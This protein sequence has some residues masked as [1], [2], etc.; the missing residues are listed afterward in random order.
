MKGRDR[1]R[2]L[3]GQWFETCI[4]LHLFA[5]TRANHLSK[6]V[7]PNSCH[8]LIENDITSLATDPKPFAVQ[9]RRAVDLDYFVKLCAR[10][11]E[12]KLE[13]TGGIYVL[14]NEQRAG[15][16]GTLKFKCMGCDKFKHVS[17]EN[18]EYGNSIDTAFVL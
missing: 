6:V 10:I 11:S 7:I 18:P 17:T 14:Q 8:V 13:C 4:V 5:Q 12:H 9:D 3:P 16:K 2:Q 1:H 15:L